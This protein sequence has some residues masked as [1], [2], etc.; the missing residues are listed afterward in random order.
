MTLDEAELE[1][2]SYRIIIRDS[3]LVGS[4]YILG[5]GKDIDYLFL[6]PDLYDTQ[7]RLKGRNW[8]D[9]LSLEYDGLGN[10]FSARRGEINLLFVEDSDFYDKWLT[11]A[12][13]C[14]ALK[15]ESRTDRVIVHR[16]IMDDMTAEKAKNPQPNP[17]EDGPAV[18]PDCS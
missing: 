16:I 14:K 10:F 1:L 15:L 6:V 9:G 7:E 4:T 2:R 8:A 12:E 13:V 5:K 11:S 17:I 3:R 18:S